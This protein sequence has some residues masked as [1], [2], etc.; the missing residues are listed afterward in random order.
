ETKPESESKPD[1]EVKPEEE[2]PAADK[3]PTVDEKPADDKASPQEDK[4]DSERTP[5]LPVEIIP[6]DYLLLP[7]VGSYGKAAIHTDPIDYLLARGKW[8]FP[9]EGEEVESSSGAK[10]KWEAKQANEEGL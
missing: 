3:E 4:P 6:R 7:A 9:T 2:K 5:Q 1:P 10:R 8:K